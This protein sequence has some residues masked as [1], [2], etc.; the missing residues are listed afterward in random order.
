MGSAAVQNVGVLSVE[1]GNLQTGLLPGQKQLAISY[2]STSI[3]M[4]R[5][6]S[7]KVD[8]RQTVRSATLS[9]GVGITRTLSLWGQVPFTEVDR[10]RSWLGG[11]PAFGLRWTPL[12]E[13]G[14]SFSLSLND[15][16]IFPLGQPLNDDPKQTNT[17]GDVQDSPFSGTGVFVNRTVA[18]AWVFSESLHLFGIQFLLDYPVT[19]R[20]DGFSP[21]RAFQVGLHSIDRRFTWWGIIPFLSLTYRGQRAGRLGEDLLDNSSGWFIY[22]T[23]AVDIRL[24]DRYRATLTAS[25][26]VVIGIEGTDL[27]QVSAGLLLRWTSPN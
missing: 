8:T 20:G 24:S 15:G 7:V 14:S 22:L 17:L 18:E 16:I 13:P 12:L 1:A 6:N 4:K 9:G 5:V 11:D 27:E 26:P 3:K 25:T 23:G 2:N 10:S 19:E 21:G